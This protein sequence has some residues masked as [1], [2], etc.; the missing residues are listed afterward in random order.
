[1]MKL[2]KSTPTKSEHGENLYAEEVV[3]ISDDLSTL[4][5]KAHEL[6]QGM[7]VKP[8]PWRSKYPLM[9]NEKIRS[10]HEWVMELGSGIGFIIEN[11]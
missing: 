4:R 6:C 8:E 3:M 7:D 5:A 9:G 2:V 10:D 1:M 11:D